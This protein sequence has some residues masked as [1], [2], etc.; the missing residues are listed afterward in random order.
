MMEL[1]EERVLGFL[2]EGTAQRNFDI[3]WQVEF[4]FP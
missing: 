3:T 1:C 2:A 4:I